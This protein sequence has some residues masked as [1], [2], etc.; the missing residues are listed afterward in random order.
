[1]SIG[2]NVIHRRGTT[3]EQIAMFAES[4]NPNTP[5]NIEKEFKAEVQG[6]CKDTWAYGRYVLQQIF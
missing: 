1:M 5:V 2:A 4:Y 6:L 3:V